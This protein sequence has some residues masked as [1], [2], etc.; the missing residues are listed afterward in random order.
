MSI[1]I[2]LIITLQLEDYLH[3]TCTYLI[4][5]VWLTDPLE[6]HFSNISGSNPPFKLTFISI[7]TPATT[8]RW[9]LDDKPFTDANS[10]T[11]LSNPVT[12]QY[13]HTLTVT[14]RLGGEY[15]CLVSSLNQNSINFFDYD[16]ISIRGMYNYIMH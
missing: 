11:V 15:K 7:K 9:T 12:T 14:E 5:F 8:V 2:L 13:T 10:V 16:E 6:V 1:L 4:T 3:L